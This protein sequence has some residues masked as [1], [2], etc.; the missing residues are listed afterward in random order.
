MWVLG[1]IFFYYV[2][3]LVYSGLF[4]FFQFLLFVFA[5]VVSYWLVGQNPEH[6]SYLITPVTLFSGISHLLVLNFFLN[7]P[8]KHIMTGV[9]TVRDH[10]IANFIN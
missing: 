3:V 8:V 4:L 9:K 10:E 1:H 6:L 2:F 7:I 5:Y